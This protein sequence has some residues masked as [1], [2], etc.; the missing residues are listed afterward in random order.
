[1]GHGTSTVSDLSVP[2]LVVSYEAALEGVPSPFLVVT[3]PNFK[4]IRN[5]PCTNK[6]LML[7]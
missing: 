4:Y 5:E 3:V 2:L 7:A 1:M 6:T